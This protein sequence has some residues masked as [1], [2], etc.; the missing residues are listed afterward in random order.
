MKA[1]GL[2][3]PLIRRLFA[4]RY[5]ATALFASICGAAASFPAGN[6]LSKN[7]SLYTGETHNGL[8][9]FIIAASGSL[10]V[11]LLVQFSCIIVL[12][13][14]KKISPVAAFRSGTE[15]KAVKHFPFF[16]LS[17]FTF[18]NTVVF[19]AFR[20]ILQRKKQ[21]LFLCLIFFFCTAVI[22]IPANFLS[23][24]S[25]ADF[26]SYMGIGRAD[27]R[28]DIRQSETFEDSIKHI[29]TTLEKDTDIAFFSPMRTIQCEYK[30]S[31]GGRDLLNLEC[32]D[33]TRFTPDFIEGR[34]PKT[35]DEIAL[36][37]INAT[38]MD[39]SPGDTMT[40]YIDERSYVM[41]VCGI[42]Q[43][44]TNGGRTAKAAI[45]DV[46]GK[47]LWYTINI[48]LKPDIN[49]S[50]KKEY[51]SKF[52]SGVRVTGIEGYL[53]E[54]LGPTIRRIRSVSYLALLSG[55]AMAVL[56]TA[57]FM[58][59]I[60][61]KDVR[62]IAILKATGFSNGDVRIQYL[63]CT[64]S[65]LAVGVLL[66]TLFSNNAG[67]SLVGFAWSFMGASQIRFI[68]HPL[69]TYF[70]LPSLLLLSVL[71][72]AVLST[73]LIRETSISRMIVE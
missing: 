9:E 38:E 65:C 11:F 14:F 48:D 53:K 16:S 42:Y 33:Y 19:L 47:P 66:G 62:S 69:Q 71:F 15:G 50:E 24:I 3:R 67:E 21:Y 52:F 30:N 60:S 39:K 32:G 29:I 35:A 59:M 41:N 68:I 7:L 64:T 58:K 2:E 45:T 8:S 34:A 36:S 31:E 61:A 1:L 25:S 22:V 55:I 46:A 17:R 28:V 51:Y 70:V 20:D 13:R 37:L 12:R 44:I 5:T 43:D 56:I 57:L 26:I 72:T 63:I 6:L 73:S 27:I 18:Q 10:A 23:T 4:A 49:T 40:L 54:T